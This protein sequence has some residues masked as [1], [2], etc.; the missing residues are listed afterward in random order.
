VFP[1]SQQEQVRIMIAGSLQGVVTQALM[2]TADGQGRAPALEILLPDDAVRNLIRQSKVEQIYSVMQTNTSRGMQTLEQS[3]AEL[4]L[5]QVIT[6]ETAMARRA[7]PTSSRVCSSAPGSR[8]SCFRKRTRRLHCASQE[9]R[10]CE[11]RAVDLEEGDLVRP[12]AEGR[13]RGAYAGSQQ[14]ARGDQGAGRRRGDPA[15][16]NARARSHAAEAAAAGAGG[17]RRREGAV[18][19]ARALLL[20]QA[21]GAEGAQAGEGEEAEEGQGAE[22]KAGEG[23]QA[24]R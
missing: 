15:A 22:G 2:P 5:R 13:R 14:R 10:C 24:A 17:G 7:V 20:T 23:A 8:S 1:P 11:R 16:G 18:L 4:T 19:Q 6:L 21:E 9:G 12:Q 3:L